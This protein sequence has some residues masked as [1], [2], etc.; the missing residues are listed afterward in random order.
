V[1]QDEIRNVLG[2]TRRI[3]V[4]GVGAESVQL[5]K[6]IRRFIEVGNL[7]PKPFTWTK[8]ADDILTSIRRFCEHTAQAHGLVQE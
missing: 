7:D 5:E 4:Y 3:G 2:S 6:D 8:A 1:K